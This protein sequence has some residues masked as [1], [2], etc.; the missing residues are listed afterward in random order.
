VSA[1]QEDRLLRPVLRQSVPLIQADQAWAAGFDGSG[2]AI[3]MLDTGVDASHPMLAGKVVS[4][5]CFSQNASCP[6][7]QATQL[8]DGAAAP[9]SYAP[10]GCAHGTYT[11]GIAAGRWDAVNLFGVARGANLI[12]VQVFSRFTG[13]TNCTQGEDPCAQ[14]FVSDVIAGMERVFELRSSFQIAA[15]NL[16]LAG[17]AYGSQAACDAANPATKAEIDNLASV[18]IA[19]VAAA[20]NDSNAQAIGEPACI[21]SAVSVGAT[22]KSDQIADFSDSASFLSLLAPGVSILSAFPGGLTAVG[23]G[24]SDSAPHVAG[25]VAILHQKAPGATVPAITSALQTSGVRLT[26]AR[27]GVTTSRINVLAALDTLSPS[28]TRG[29]GIR[30]TPDANRTLISKDING[31]RWAIVYNHDDQ[32]VTGNVFT[33]AGGPPKFIWCRRVSDNGDPD[34]DT[35]Q[36]TF[37]CSGTDGCTAS[38]CSTIWQPIG[39]STL[40]GSFFRQP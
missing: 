25:A 13:S 12:A 33:S 16:S 5:A 2:W 1:V 17:Q 39:D 18:G 31:E 22:T 20:G 37:E 32:T 36:I 24:T 29:S 35:I 11:A 10:Q 34:P 27:N 30:D 4:Q 3:A 23:S 38:P 28:A 14:S 19:T 15:V 9:C 7:G 26:D 40:P 6:N 21:S 8:G